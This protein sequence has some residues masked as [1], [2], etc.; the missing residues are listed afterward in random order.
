MSSLN[1]THRYSQQ[2]D[3][4]TKQLFNTSNILIL[5]AVVLAIVLKSWWYLLIIVATVLF[6]PIYVQTR[7]TVAVYDLTD[8]Q[9]MTVNNREWIQFK[10]DH[11]DQIGKNGEK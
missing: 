3:R 7:K 1:Q 5:L 8:Q 2:A 4:R 6:W 10:K 9:E 11:P